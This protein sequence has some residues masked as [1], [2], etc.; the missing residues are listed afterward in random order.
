MMRAYP[1]WFNQ[2]TVI[3]FHSWLIQYGDFTA[4]CDPIVIIRQYIYIERN[5]IIQK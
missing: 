3:Q 1:T 5:H 4:S 2:F